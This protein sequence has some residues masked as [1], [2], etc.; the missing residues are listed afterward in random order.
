MHQ[1]GGRELD[2]RAIPL[3]EVIKDSESRC[4]FNSNN[5]WEEGRPEDYDLVMDKTQTINWIDRFHDSR[6]IRII[7]IGPSDVS[8]MQEAELVCTY[9][10]V[11]STLFQDK[12][13]DYVSSHPG[14]SETMSSYP[15]S[16]IKKASGWFVR[17]D[18]TSLKDGEFGIGPYN[19]LEKLLKSLCTSRRGHSPI[20][21][22]APGKFLTV[23]LIPWVTIAREYRMFCYNKKITCISQQNV[24]KRFGWSEEI[25]REDSALLL[26]Y[27]Y[28]KIE[29]C[30]VYDNV[31]IDIAILDDGTPYFI[32]FNSFGKEYASG[33]ALFHWILDYDLLYSDGEKVHVR[34][35]V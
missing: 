12:I 18:W 24:Y 21:R 16:G 11:F 27:F 28:H 15:D 8:W 25:L 17:T 26:N 20:S 22:C 5:H 32:E 2:V 23:Y 10:G 7:L 31:T 34:Y 6:K 33:S 4:R 1:F 9:R 30:L 29:D 3:Q 35:T 19:C 13:E 14:E